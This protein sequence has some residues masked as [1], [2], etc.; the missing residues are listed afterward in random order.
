MTSTT[1]FRGLALASIVL[2]CAA[3]SAATLE[4]SA[5]VQE[6]AVNGATTS[7][8]AYPFAV[9]IDVT[10]AG[11]VR[12]CSGAIIAPRVVLTAGH[13]TP[14][15]RSYMIRAPFANG[16]TRTT[17]DVLPLAT[18]WGNGIDLALLF[19]PA[20]EAFNLNWYPARADAIPDV[21]FPTRI[22]GRISQGGA[23][24]EQLRLSAPLLSQ[25]Y[26]ANYIVATQWY[27]VVAGE[28]GDSGGPLLRSNTRE[29]VGV[30]SNGPDHTVGVDQYTR[31]DSVRCWI[32]DQV[33]AHGGEGKRFNGS[34]PG[35]S[36]ACPR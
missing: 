20:G 32:E 18:R 9:K 3:C 12:K 28:H 21:T 26:D 5:E 29:I 14:G 1:R 11:R 13:C 23:E 7:A 36:A 24:Q 33:A 19:L 22:I 35:R 16:A 2:L 6:A 31:I 27:F 30:L 34:R 4:P 25:I 10:I 15:G 17:S 8:T